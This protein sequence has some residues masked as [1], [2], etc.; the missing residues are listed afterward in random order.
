[1]N[2]P[3]CPYCGAAVQLRFTAADRNRNLASERF[4]YHECDGCGLIFLWPVPEELG[5]FYPPDY[6]ELPVSRSDLVSRSWPHEAYKIE[7]LRDLAPGRRLAEVGPGIGGFAALAQDAGYDVSVIEMDARACAFLERTVGVRVH[8][9][10]DA[11]GA[12]QRAGPFDVIAMWHVIEHLR[13]PFG[14]LSAVAA[15]LAP[16]GVAVIAAPNPEA[17]QLRLFGR[18]WTHLDAPRHLFLIP[19]A[20]LAEA[21]TARGLEVAEVTTTDAGSLGWNRFGWRE[22]LAHSVRGRYTAHALRLVG[23]VPAVLAAPIERRDRLGATYTMALRRP[24][25]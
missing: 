14:T 4:G 11:P 24:L 21:A 9:T 3:H 15:A 8:H 2:P 18:R 25:R 5:R 10:E 19:I 20:T 17:L 16:G 22:T 12:L 1:M 6:Y 13:D 7:L 23:T